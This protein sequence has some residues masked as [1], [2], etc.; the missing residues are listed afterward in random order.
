MWLFETGLQSYLENNGLLLA[1]GLK[2]LLQLQT[3]EALFFFCVL[4]VALLKQLLSAAKA[5][6]F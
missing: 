3:G 4:F 5:T 1:F 2:S 6:A